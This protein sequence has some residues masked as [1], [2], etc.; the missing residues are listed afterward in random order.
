MPAPRSFPQLTLL[1]YLYCYA[2]FHLIAGNGDFGFSLL[3]SCDDAFLVYFRNLFIGGLISNLRAVL[4]LYGNA[5]A[6]RFSF[7][8]LIR[9]LFEPDFG[10]AG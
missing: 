9:L 1:F 2:L 6:N 4:V 8:D 10:P 5:K 7:F 3:H